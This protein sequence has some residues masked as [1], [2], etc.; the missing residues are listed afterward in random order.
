M[1]VQIV[2]IDCA[3]EDKR[4]G[5][6]LGRLEGG[7]LYVDRVCTCSPAGPARCTVAEWVRGTSAPTLL[8]IDAPLGWPAQMGRV[9]HDHRAGSAISVESNQ[10]FR[11]E[12]DRFVK[13]LIGINPLDV[14]ADRIARTA[15]AALNLLA[16]LSLD[17]QSAIPIAWKTPLEDSISAIEVYPAATLASYG[18]RSRKYKRRDQTDERRSLLR[19][20]A[21]FA[22]LP[23]DQS[24]MEKSAD[25]LDAA[26]C[27]IAASDF[28]LARAI[29]PEDRALA[30]VEGW[31]WVRRPDRHQV[32]RAL[33]ELY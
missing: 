33:S 32:Q 22:V 10:F 12:T 5:L 30:D 3:T 2:G 4:V 27:L 11:R 29:P 15:H 21:S 8:A 9:L 14:G 28:L 1:S 23:A 20:L 26:V 31:I 13:K 24:P 19:E 16:E 25:A 7:R 6:A 18:L 17:L